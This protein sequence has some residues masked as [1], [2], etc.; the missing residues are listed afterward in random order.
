M[1]Y[2]AIISVAHRAAVGVDNYPDRRV[3]SPAMLLSAGHRWRS[4]KRLCARRCRREPILVMQACQDRSSMRESSRSQSMQPIDVRI[5]TSVSVRVAAEDLGHQ[6]PGRCA[7]SP[8]S[9]IPRLDAELICSRPR[10]FPNHARNGDW[11][12]AATADRFGEIQTTTPKVWSWPSSV[13]VWIVLLAGNRTSSGVWRLKFERHLERLVVA[14]LGRCIGH[15][16]RRK[17]DIQRDP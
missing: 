12:G 4:D 3:A 6:Y 7:V 16:A 9:H 8:P 1:P 11:F 5:L 17:A 13:D 2:S 10:L 14:E 15:I